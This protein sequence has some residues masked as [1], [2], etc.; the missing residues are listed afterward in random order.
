MLN[1]FTAST[2]DTTMYYDRKTALNL[3]KQLRNGEITSVKLAWNLVYNEQQFVAWI[4]KGIHENIYSKG[5]GV[6]PHCN[7]TTGERKFLAQR[8]NAERDRESVRMWVENRIRVQPTGLTSTYYR[9][10][11]QNPELLENLVYLTKN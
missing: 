9:K 2:P 7:I 6:F 4:R 11:R 3:L 5:N 8:N 1:R 10:Y